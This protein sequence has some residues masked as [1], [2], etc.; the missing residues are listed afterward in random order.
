MYFLALFKNAKVSKLVDYEDMTDASYGQA[1]LDEQGIP[2]LVL[3]ADSSQ[4][5]LD[6]LMIN[7]VPMCDVVQTPES[8]E[9]AW[10]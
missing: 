10:L 6:K 8:E 9:A 7:N 1:H 5:C 2:S 4:D 3:E